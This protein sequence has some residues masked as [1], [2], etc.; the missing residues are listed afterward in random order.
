METTFYEK[1]DAVKA[2]IGKLTKDIDNT[3]FKCKYFDINQLLEH[4]EGLLRENGLM[5]LQPLVDGHVVTKII[6]PKTG[7]SEE[8]S[9]KI[10]E[11]NDP[12]KIGSAITY[13]RR[14]TLQSLLALQAEDDDANNAS[15]KGEAKKP[16]TNQQEDNRPWLNEKQFDQAVTR[17]KGGESGVYEKIDAAFKMKK[18]YRDTLKNT[19]PNLSAA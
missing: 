18:Q 15:G 6:D 17:I 5:V 11:L 19:K 4:C 12:Q 13:Y 7:E 10:P 2:K 16:A 9:I 8:S 14:Y 3:F 1:L